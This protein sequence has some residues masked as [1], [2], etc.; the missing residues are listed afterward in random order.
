[1]D[2]GTTTGGYGGRGATQVATTP[3]FQPRSNDYAEQAGKLWGATRDSFVKNIG[4]PYMD[5]V[6]KN[7]G[8]DGRKPT[9]ESEIVMAATPRDWGG[10][11]PVNRHVAATFKSPKTNDIAG[12]EAAGRASA[13]TAPGG[14]KPNDIAGYE[15]AGRAS[16]Q[17]APGGP[18]PNDIAGY[19]AAGRASAQT[20][21]GKGGGTP[22]WLSTLGSTA[23]RLATGAL[24]STL[25]Q[26]LTA[27][28]APTGP[29]QP[30]APAA[31]AAPAAPGGSTLNQTRSQMFDSQI[32]RAQSK[33]NKNLVSYL[34]NMRDSAPSMQAGYGDPNREET[35][36]Q[37]RNNEITYGQHSNNELAA[38]STKTAPEVAALR[39]SRQDSRPGYNQ[40]PQPQMAQSQ[41]GGG[42]GFMHPGLKAGNGNSGQ[43]GA[44]NFG[45]KNNLN[46]ESPRATVTRGDI[47]QADG[48]VQGIDSNINRLQQMARNTGGAPAGGMP[49]VAGALASSG[50]GKPPAGSTGPGF[51][52][53]LQRGPVNGGTVDM[54]R[55]QP[56]Q[57]M[58]AGGAAPKPMPAA[59]K[60]MNMPMA[61][62]SGAGATMGATMPTG[63]GGGAQGV[64]PTG[65]IKPAP[66]AG[67][68]KP[69]SLM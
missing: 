29:Q 38:H 55:P 17:T 30:M 65:A 39:A 22:S 62:A 28:G 31:P 56:A 32:A 7:H 15:A 43:L 11:T 8:M 16:A 68:P 57:M 37:W 64:K 23:G 6:W 10:G 42:N 51:S 9:P 49:N 5:E 2:D 1:M 18:K 25:Q 61:G 19:E 14:P 36:N 52:D 66:I 40:L 46:Y 12:Y 21:P 59:P 13:Q 34:T 63:M 58:P 33:G 50:I 48:R 44:S 53:L 35:R 69:G 67:M 27:P 26:P 54:M 45:Y 24:G 41:F 4:K 60:P 3:G 47:A 20:A